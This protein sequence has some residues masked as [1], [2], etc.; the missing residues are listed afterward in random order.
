MGERPGLSASRTRQDE[1]R[2][3]PV[4]DGLALRGVQ[5][6]ED[7]G[8]GLQG[9]SESTG[10]PSLLLLDGH[11]LGQVAWL[12]DVRPLQRCDLVG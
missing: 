1:Q 8:D 12:V 5:V 10:R 7:P 6:F 4:Q 2:S 9:G 11:T 3:V